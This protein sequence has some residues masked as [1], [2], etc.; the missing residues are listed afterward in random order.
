MDSSADVWDPSSTL[1]SGRLDYEALLTLLGT[2]F[3]CGRTLM[4]EGFVLKFRA[5]APGI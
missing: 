5:K 3:N 2:G 1:G 4:L